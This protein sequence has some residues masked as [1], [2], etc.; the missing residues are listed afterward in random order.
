MVF[1]DSR[2]AFREL[3]PGRMIEMS[4]YSQNL[5]DNDKKLAALVQEMKKRFLN[6]VDAIAAAPLESWGKYPKA[7]PVEPIDIDAAILGHIAGAGVKPRFKY[8]GKKLAGAV[9]IGTYALSPDSTC[10]WGGMDLDGDGGGHKYPLKD[11][12]GAALIILRNLKQYGITAYLVK[13]GSATGWHIWVLLDKPIPAADLRRFLYAVIPDDVPLKNGGYA[14][15]KARGIEVFPKQDTINEVD[16]YGNQMWLP[17]FHGTRGINGGRFYSY[18]D[19]KIGDPIAP[20]HFDTASAEKIVEIAKTLPK[21]EERRYSSKRSTK[22]R[23]GDDSGDESV[24]LDADVIERVVAHLKSAPIAFSGKGGD[25]QTYTV[26]CDVVRGFGVPEDQALELMLKYYSPRC[27]PPWELHELASKVRSAAKNRKYERGW[28]LKKGVLPW[29][30]PKVLPHARQPLPLLGEE[31]ILESIREWL[32]DQCER[33]GLTLEFGFVS[34]LCLASTLIG[35]K[36]GIHPKRL[37]DWLVICNLWGVLV[38]LPSSMKSP[39]LKLASERLARL[40]KEATKAFQDAL[41]VLNTKRKKLEFDIGMLEEDA[42]KAYRKPDTGDYNA[43]LDQKLL[44]EAE[45]ESLKITQKR[46]W[47]NSA[48]MAKLLDLFIENPSGM[49]WWRDELSGLLKD[50]ERPGNESDRQLLLEMWDGNNPYMADRKV[51]TSSAVDGMCLTLLGAIQPSAFE[52]YVNEAIRGDG[53]DGLLS[54]FQLAV[55]P[56]RP[57]PYKRV[58]R[59]PNQ[60]ADDQVFEIIKKLDALT[61]WNLDSSDSGAVGNPVGDLTWI[62]KGVRFSDEAQTLADAWTDAI[63]IEYREVEKVCEAFGSHLGKYRSFMPSLALIYHMIFWA[64][65]EEQNFDRVSLKATQLA[66]ASVDLFKEHARKI[67]APALRS[68]ILSAHNIMAKIKRRMVVDGTSVSELSQR[69]LKGMA[70]AD[71]AW[72]GVEYLE[73]LGWVQIETVRPK[74]GVGASSSVIRLNPYLFDDGG[75]LKP[76]YVDP[77]DPETEAPTFK[78]KWLTWVPEGT[79]MK[80]VNNVVDLARRREQQRVEPERDLNAELAAAARRNDAECVLKLLDE[81][82]EP[83]PLHV[84]VDDWLSDRYEEVYKL[85]EGRVAGKIAALL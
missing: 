22:E 16:G 60:E 12:D 30:M 78:S 21:P 31:M 63:N 45:L 23:D 62:I 77:Y 39:A 43:I 81:G 59:K 52:K 37:D 8:R 36:V 73:S 15:K 53:G 80:P 41:S 79:E 24:T 61:P 70:N 69:H 32:L 1:P 50:L 83:V 47:T 38:G 19:E 14:D 28:I 84:F 5:V 54:R 26:A 82:A 76:E 75:K 51:A 25:W 4:N 46:Y 27:V 56:D 2:K 9:K 7:M 64:S 29:G 42:K 44:K 6:R 57:K 17:L 68:E 85:L 65:G 40:Q 35:R 55:F 66:A 58:D 49:M 18:N 3:I 48:S 67:Y 74:G 11:V 71:A 13:S 20:I 34:F 10:I 72:K 33:K